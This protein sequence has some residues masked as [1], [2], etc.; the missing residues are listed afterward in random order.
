MCEYAQSAGLKILTI[1]ELERLNIEHPKYWSDETLI[2]QY[3]N[4]NREFHI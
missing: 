4:A 2:E 1:G 3:G